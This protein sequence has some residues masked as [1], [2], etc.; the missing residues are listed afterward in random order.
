MCFLY[1]LKSYYYPTISITLSIIL[2]TEMSKVYPL[3][4]EASV[5]WNWIALKRIAINCTNL[6]TLF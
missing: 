5:C 4:V 6:T 1:S 3:V 2:A